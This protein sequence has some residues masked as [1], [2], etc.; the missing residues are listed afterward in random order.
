MPSETNMRQ[1]EMNRL[2][3][4]VEALQIT[5]QNA[6]MNEA[7]AT[8][9]AAKNAAKKIKNN[10]MRKLQS[11]AAAS[12]LMQRPVAAPVRLPPSASGYTYN[13]KPKSTGG[14]RRSH[15]KSHK[16]RRSTRRR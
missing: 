9:N 4:E 2:R 13:I 6:N 5:V 14:R 1:Q 8:N 10:A 12:A 7:R 16:K 11:L 15:K 3:R